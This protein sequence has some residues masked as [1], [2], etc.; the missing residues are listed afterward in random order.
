MNNIQLI[1]TK[2]YAYAETL[3]K[4]DDHCKEHCLLL[5]ANILKMSTDEFF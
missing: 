5:M 3:A 1:I 2:I 4:K